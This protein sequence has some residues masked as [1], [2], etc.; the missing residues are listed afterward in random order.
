MQTWTVTND[1]CFGDGSVEVQL[2]L[3]AC[4]DSE[5]NCNDGQ[6]VSMADR[7][8]GIINCNDKTGRLC[9]NLVAV[10]FTTNT[11][12]QKHI[13]NKFSD[14]VDCFVY[15]KDFSYLKNMPPEAL[16]NDSALIVDLELDILTILDIAEVKS[17][18]SMQVEIHLS[19]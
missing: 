6:C 11:F 2:N 19:W 10:I 3:N 4:S 9:Y 18:M 7:C 17:Y 12:S 14:E 16:N 15:E 8:D 1:P 13:T 5:F